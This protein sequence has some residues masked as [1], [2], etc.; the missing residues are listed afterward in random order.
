MEFN[1]VFKGLN[2]QVQAIYSGYGGASDVTPTPLLV[3]LNDSQYK[4]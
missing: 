2:K 3:P 4:N 1:S